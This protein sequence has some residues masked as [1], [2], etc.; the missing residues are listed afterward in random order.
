MS[1]GETY[2]AAAYFVFLA[3]VLV[4]VVI[5]VTRL[6]RME[7][8]V[9]KLREEAARRDDPQREREPEPVG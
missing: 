7:R 8:E 6:G 3:L 9:E 5:M 1:S 4:Y 2:L